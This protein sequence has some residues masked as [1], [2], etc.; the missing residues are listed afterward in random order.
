M[1]TPKRSEPSGRSGWKRPGDDAQPELLELGRISGVFGV[2]GEVRL[3]LHNRESELL[4]EPRDVVLTGPKG[5]TRKVRL[6]ARPGAGG[7][8]I[9]VID[10]LED[11]DE[12]ASLQEW[13]VWIPLADLPEL[14]DDEFYIQEVIGAEVRVGDEVVGTITEVHSTG[15]NEIFEVRLRGGGVGYVPALTTHVVAIDLEEHVVELVP[16]AIAVDR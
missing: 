7:R 3:F 13:K 16:E 14:D 9:G 10:G 4:D 8:I 11:R 2:R 5:Q 15:P 6:R 1:G 12:A